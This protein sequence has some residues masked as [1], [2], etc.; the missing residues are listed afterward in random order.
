MFLEKKFSSRLKWFIK[1]KPVRQA[2]GLSRAAGPYQAEV[3]ALVL[4]AAS[5]TKTGKPFLVG[6][7]EVH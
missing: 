7:L 5:A 6:K 3:A 2:E 4:P 1:N